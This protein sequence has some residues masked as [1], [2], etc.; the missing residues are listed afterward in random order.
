MSPRRE[1]VI[2]LDSRLENVALAGRAL[3]GLGAEAGLGPLECDQLELCVVEAVTNCVVH[4]YNGQ[5]GNEVRLRVALGEGALEVQ[6][7][8]RGSPIPPG[9]L[10]PREPELPEDALTLAEHGRGL[11]ILRMLMDSLD[12]TSDARGNVLTLVKRVGAAAGPPP[13]LADR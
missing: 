6:V 13:P 2:T 11:L 5:P 1:I 12:Y 7:V 10:E 4:A 3:H 9:A 8:D